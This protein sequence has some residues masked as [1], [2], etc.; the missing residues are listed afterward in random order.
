MMTSPQFRE[1]PETAKFQ[2]ADFSAAGTD[3]THT[4]KDRNN[5]NHN[6]GDSEAIGAF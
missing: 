2:A 4:V 6:L 1:S 3:V 5:S